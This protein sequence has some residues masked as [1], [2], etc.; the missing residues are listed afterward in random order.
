MAERDVQELVPETHVL[1]V[2][3]HVGA[4]SK[5]PYVGNTMATFCM[6]TLGCEVSAIHTVNYSNHVAYRTFTGRK[7]TPTEISDLYSGLKSALL[8]NFDVLLSGYCPSAALVHEVGK[9]GRDN[10]TRAATKPGSF[11]WILDPVMGDNGRIYV[12]EEC[13]E[14]Y[15]GLLKDADLILPNLFEAELLSGEKIRDL[16]SMG[17]AIGKLHQV[18]AVPNVVVTSIR[19]PE[20]PIAGM[21]EEGKNSSAVLS[22]IGSTATSEGKPRLFRIT[23]P[24][25]PVFFSGTGDM[26]AAL[27]VARLREAAQQAG[28][29]NT[30]SWRSPDEVSGPELPLAKAVS[31][32]LASMHAVLKDTAKHY[33]A[34]SKSLGEEKV[35]NEGVGEAAEREREMERHLKLTRAAEVRVV[36]NMRALR[37]PPE[38]E[39]FRAQ[40]VDV[41]G[42]GGDA[43]PA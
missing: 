26:F 21:G 12:A 11:F 4:P 5:S 28:V 41:R 10:K 23:V 3:S 9:I 29:L 16:E 14:A 38:L 33:Q 6:Q 19:L 30:A 18:F 39:K 15:K 1:A 35:L 36:R 43:E 34:V 22:V 27:L 32:V 31:K 8:H 7:T 24:A 2:A 13:V 42:E 17:V 40:A 25:L 37:E 20:T